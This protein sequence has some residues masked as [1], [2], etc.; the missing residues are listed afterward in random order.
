[1]INPDEIRN[2]L[3]VRRYGIGNFIFTLPFI[4]HCEALFPK[5]NIHL[6]LDARCRQIANLARPDLPAIFI[7][8]DTENAL[9]E[10]DADLSFVAYPC[11]DAGLADMVRSYSRVS[12]GYDTGNL[13]GQFTRNLK[14]DPKKHEV[15]LN[16]DML[17][18][19]G[20]D[21]QASDP[22]IELSE[23]LIKDGRDF[24]KQWQVLQPYVVIHPGSNED[25]RIKRW[26]PDRYA[27]L[28]DLLADKGFTSLLVGSK[29][30]TDLCAEVEKHCR[31]RPVNLAGKD[32]IPLCAAIMKGAKAV[33]AN[34]SGLM[35]LAASIQTPVI[36]IFGPTSHMRNPP[37]C[38]KH[39][40]VRRP[41]SCS[42]CYVPGSPLPACRAWCLEMVTPEMVFEAFENLIHDR[43]FHNPGRHSPFVSVIAPTFNGEKKIGGLLES[44][45]KQSYPRDRFEVIVVDNNSKDNTKREIQKFTNVRYEFYADRQ[46]SYAARNHGIKK[47]KGKIL[48]FTDDDCAADPDWIANAVQWF[49]HPDIG[50]VAGKVIGAPSDNDIARWQSRRG[51]LDLHPDIEA[52]TRPAIV[53]ANVF[54]RRDVFNHVGSFDES[55]VSSGDHEMAWRMIR[56]SRYV[57]R[58]AQDAIVHHHHRETLTSLFRAFFR[59]GFGHVDL[60]KRFPLDDLSTSER[61]GNAIKT[62]KSLIRQAYSF[63]TRDC[64][65]EAIAGIRDERP[66][67]FFSRCAGDGY[68]L[69]TDG[70]ADSAMLE[71]AAEQGLQI[72]KAPLPPS[73]EYLDAGVQALIKENHPNLFLYAA[74]QHT[75]R[76]MTRPDFS[77]LNIKGVIDDKAAPDQTVGSLPVVS[78]EEALRRGCK[79]ILISTDAFEH[80]LIPKLADLKNQGV[81]VLGL[82]D[83]KA[84]E[85]LARS[86]GNVFLQQPTDR[87]AV[88]IP[89]HRLADN[90]VSALAHG[91]GIQ[92]RLDATFNTRYSDQFLDWVITTAKRL[93][94]I[95]GSIRYRH[96]YV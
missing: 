89:P 16:L 24:L 5:A 48:A 54:Y 59:Y 86:E 94:R 90:L 96:L 69:T 37:L 34:D 26:K 19:V 38:E 28:V 55:M 22:S 30:E 27:G 46:T 79:T 78:L 42:P 65:P 57:F 10:I 6:V 13:Q 92:I 91:A 83:E 87:K 21:V 33:F 3:I 25:L 14:A 72:I 58:A 9:K 17:K 44:L 51:F 29:D 20:F 35:H 63:A 52:S 61:I 82:Y 60:D 75:R 41:A 88:F 84:M 15:D 64:S 66:E 8:R 2:V 74:G 36:A 32:T 43:P 50:G 80:V 1:M 56:G 76:M 71:S 70:L 67:D 12:V 18:A 77:S 62:W 45:E 93:G 31:C 4:S 40:I 68:I 81:R 23:E 39:R 73:V 49:E 11:A 85:R 95:A 7:G 53:T 47:A